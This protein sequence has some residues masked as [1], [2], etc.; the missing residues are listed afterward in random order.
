MDKA[1]FSIK[2]FNK[3][4]HKC[5][6]SKLPTDFYEAEENYISQVTLVLLLRIIWTL[7]SYIKCVFTEEKNTYISSSLT[8][9]YLKV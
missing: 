6:Q 5:D 9:P 1:D 7:N 4:D 2:T 8:L 3:T